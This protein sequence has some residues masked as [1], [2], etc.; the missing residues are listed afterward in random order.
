MSLLQLFSSSADCGIRLWDLRS[1]LCLCVLQSH[2]SAVTSLAFTASGDT[3]VRYANTLGVVLPLPVMCHSI[4]IS[5][6][7][8]LRRDGFNCVVLYCFWPSCLQLWQGQD[9][10]SVGSEDADSHKNRAGL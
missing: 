7:L 9:L 4:D 8:P 2:F 10:Y 1:S 3:M 5:I 6:D